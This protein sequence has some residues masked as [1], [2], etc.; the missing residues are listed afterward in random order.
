MLPAGT[1]CSPPCDLFP[2]P[3]TYEAEGDLP[4]AFNRFRQRLREERL[5][6]NVEHGLLGSTFVLCGL[7]YDS[8]RVEALYRDLGM[9]LE[10]S[11]TYQLI[12]NKGLAQGAL[13]EAQRLVLLFGAKRFGP[14]PG[15]TESALRSI[16][17]RDRLERMIERTQEATG[18]DDVLATS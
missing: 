2:D 13:T 6:D 17:D 15:A 4:T 1:M 5:P 16:A 12:L 14:A 7:R 18:W 3:V 9:T 11:T 10:D 8:V